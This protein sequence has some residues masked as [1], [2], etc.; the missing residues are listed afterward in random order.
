MNE[1]SPLFFSVFLKKKIF[2]DPVNSKKAPK[3][4]LFC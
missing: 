1:Y 4:K 3:K 2:S